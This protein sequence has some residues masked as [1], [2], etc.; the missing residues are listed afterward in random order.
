M[1]TLLSFTPG[2]V[3]TV[4]FMT[5]FCP[6]LSAKGITETMNVPGW[7]T[8]KVIAECMVLLVVI[9]LPLLKKRIVIPGK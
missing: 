5:L 2:L 3:T 4:I 8:G 1:K 7:G 6:T 9:I